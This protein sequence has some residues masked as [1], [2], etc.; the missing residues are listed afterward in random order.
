MIKFLAYCI[1]YCFYPLSFLFPRKEDLLVFG[2]YRGGFNENSKY[3]YLYCREH[4]KNKRAVWISTKRETVEQMRSKGLESYYLGTPLGVWFALRGKY[5]FVNAYT[6]DIMFCLAGGAKLI[7]LWH[8][9]PWKCIEFGIKKGALAR[10]Y[11]RED[12]LDAFEHPAIFR[13]P[14]FVASGSE[15][16]TDIFADAFRVEK[17]KCLPCG[18]PRDRLLF[19]TLGE[20]KDFIHR[21]E[22]DATLQLV[23]KLEKFDKVYI[24]MPTW[25]D[26]QRDFFST[27][28]DLQT[29]NE[30]M[31]Q[32]NACLLLKPHPNTILPS[33]KSLS[34]VFFVDKLADIYCILPFTN[35]LITDYSSVMFDYP[36]MPRKGMLLYQ[37]DYNEYLREREFNFPLEGNIIG[38]KVENFDELIQSIQHD[39]DTLKED[40]RQV[41]VQKF[42]GETMNPEQDVCKN[43]LDRVCGV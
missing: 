4:V 19:A 20:V 10:R 12:W 21:Y 22:S 13:R 35:V 28:M 27:G 33:V 23:E 8:G 39:V 15:F 16:V 9:I 41:F 24:Y 3:L 34:H 38:K 1:C 43:I 29:M 6:S 2:S 42:W 30:V 5:W 18:Y 17:A 11:T 32:K 25:R 37:Y 36:L 26:S 31:R 14:D 7:N 40:E